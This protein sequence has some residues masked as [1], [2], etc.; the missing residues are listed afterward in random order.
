MNYFFKAGIWAVITYIF[1][2]VFGTNS[3]WMV[4]FSVFLFSIPV[5]LCGVYGSTICQIRRLNIFAARGWIY[6]LLTTRTTRI[7]LWIAWALLS[8]FFMLIQFHTYDTLEWSIFFLVIPVF[9]GI[10]YFIRRF[11]IKELKP[12]LVT[13]M[14]L[15]WSRRLCPVVMLLIYLLLVGYIGETTQ[16]NSIQEAIDARKI[17][18]SDM[19]GSAV[20]FEVSQ[21]LAFYDGVKL[22]ALSHLGRIDAFGAMILSAIGTIVVFYNACAMLSC[23]LIPGIEYR[24]IFGPLSDEDIPPKIKRKRIFGILTIITFLSFFVYVPIFAYIEFTVQQNLGIKERREQFESLTIAGIERVERIGNHYYK[25]GTIEKLQDAKVQALRRQADVAIVQLEAHADRAF[26]RV[27]ANVDPFLDWYYSLVGEYTRIATLMVGDLEDY[28]IQKLSEY[29]QHS[30]PFSSFETAFNRLIKEYE[31]ARKNYEQLAHQIMKK[32]QIEQS[33]KPFPEIQV[34]SLDDI[35]T[36]PLH[37]DTINLGYRMGGSGGGAALAGAV[38]AVVVKKIIVKLAGKNVFKLA[39][40]VL[41]KV[42]LGKTAG[43]AAGASVGTSVGAFVGSVVPILG[44]AAGA[45]VGGVAG[46]IIAGVS[47]DKLLLEL[48]ELIGREAFKAT[49]LEAIQGARSEFKAQ[50]RR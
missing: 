50:L 4:V 27:E 37:E 7:S 20:I 44:T 11:V 17:S 30:D 41:L 46:G 45:V 34:A 28:L 13:S 48:E 29:L 33:E 26:D 24:R 49:I 2:Q 8:S 21:Y 16:F 36:I 3:L 42:V 23:F 25:I 15:A 12:Y 9:W 10:Y 38:T 19:R 40:K 18:V 5:S 39:A 14:A 32:N 1:A 43:T 31:T 47:V 6:K 35:L 22:Y